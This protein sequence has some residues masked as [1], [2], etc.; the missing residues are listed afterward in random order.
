MTDP[1]SD[2]VLGEVPVHAAVLRA[3]AD[4]LD[5]LND[6]FANADPAAR[7]QLGRYLVDRNGHQNTGDST[8]EAA[9]TLVELSEA[10]ELLHTLAGNYRPNTAGDP[11]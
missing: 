10:A 8:I 5:L 3:T 2:D 6:F 4:L 7:A 1:A 9:V 11:D